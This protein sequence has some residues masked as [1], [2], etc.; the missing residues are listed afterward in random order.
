MKV[1]IHKRYLK[2]FPFALHK[3]EILCL[4]GQVGSGR[5]DVMRAIFGVDKMESGKISLF[6]KLANINTPIDAINSG[7]GF[8]T[9]DR[10]NQGIILS[11][12]MVDNINMGNYEK[13]SR[14]GFIQ[15]DK[16][17]KVSEKYRDSLNIKNSNLK[18]LTKFLSGGN[19]QKVILAKW[20]NH[21]PKILFMDEPTKGIDVGAKQE[22]Y[23]LIR[24]L[25]ERGMAVLLITSELNEAL[26]LSDRILVFCKGSI[27]G[28]LKPH[29]TTEEEVMSLTL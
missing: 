13:S 1:S 2:I 11:M 15:L 5:T 17:K 4:F 29:E 18:L 16:V 8:I 10:K 20:L 24:D 22:F 3:G 14:L 19:Q 27:V 26:G 7:I 12:D 21:D 28:E 23:Q 25:A 9:E 6:G